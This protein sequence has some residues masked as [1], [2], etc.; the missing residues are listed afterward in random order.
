MRIKYNTEIDN[1]I[2]IKELKK[3][4][5]QIYKLLPSREENLN[6]EKPLETIMIEL[7]GMSR[8]FVDRHDILFPIL[9]KMEALFTLTNR[10]DFEL[11][12]RTIFE[13]LGLMNGIIKDDKFR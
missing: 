11:F 3:L 4:I 8:L 12:R 10:E 2:I 1:E 13:C 7:T 9:C 5:N 6:W